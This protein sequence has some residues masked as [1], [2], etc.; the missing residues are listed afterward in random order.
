MALTLSLRPK[1]F[2]C[3]LKTR[4]MFLTLAWYF[5]ARSSE[6]G[7][8][9][10]NLPYSLFIRLQ[11]EKV[12]I[13][14]EAAPFPKNLELKFSYS[15]FLT[16]LLIRLS[17]LST[18]LANATSFCFVFSVYF[19][20]KNW[21]SS[22]SCEHSLSWRLCWLALEVESS[23]RKAWSSMEPASLR[24]W[25]DNSTWLEFMIKCWWFLNE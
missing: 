8:S 11:F 25:I 13:L 21:H 3:I 17:V 9:H 10:I 19:F 1:S 23:E 7:K 14:S 22:S 4:I 12:S 20:S 16:I 5:I 2:I 6:S 24:A 15:K 18:C